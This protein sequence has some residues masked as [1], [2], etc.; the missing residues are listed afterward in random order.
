MNR[1][2][3]QL[4]AEYKLK[5]AKVDREFH[6]SV[7]GE[8]GPLQERLESLGELLCLCVGAFGDISADLERLIGAIAE[9]RALFLSRERGRPL[10]DKAGLIL[11]Q[12]R[13]VLSVVFVR[14]QAACLVAR[15]GHLGEAAQGCAARR[16]VAKAEAK[17]LREEAAAFH[18]AHMRGRGRWTGA[19]GRGG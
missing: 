18:S 7:P 3:R 2:A 17:R 6:G 12:H 16:D 14:V 9:S 8:V 19:G 5:V 4:P 15:M 10:S 13:R 11:C 1:R